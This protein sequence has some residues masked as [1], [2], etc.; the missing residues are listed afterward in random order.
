MN[1]R[2]TQK[3]WLEER[4]GA[5]R[6]HLRANFYPPYPAEATDIVI[7]EFTRY[8]KEQ[9]SR[10]LLQ[11]RIRQAWKRRTGGNCEL[12]IDHRFETF[13]LDP[14]EEE[15]YRPLPSEKPWAFSTTKVRRISKNVRQV[16]K[17]SDIRRLNKEAYNLIILH[18]GFIAHYNLYGFQDEYANVHEFA[19]T[20]LTSEYSRDPRDTTNRAARIEE[21]YKHE[22]G[23][24]V[25]GKRTAQTIRAIILAARQYMNGTI[26]NVIH[27]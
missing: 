19:R 6:M 20:L 4:A 7:R 21:Q 26:Q 18:M 27:G 3:Q 12:E 14:D 2:Q 8:W 9:C 16:F 24:E 15:A 11:R 25:Y 17:H 5:L 1:E 23:K 10:L 22:E 13:L